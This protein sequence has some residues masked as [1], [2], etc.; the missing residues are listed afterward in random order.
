[1]NV[2]LQRRTMKNSDMFTGTLKGVGVGG[3]DGIH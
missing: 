3:I 2:M 1:M